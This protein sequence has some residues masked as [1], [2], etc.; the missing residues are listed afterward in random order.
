MTN[1]VEQKLDSFLNKDEAKNTEDALEAPISQEDIDAV[2]N[3]LDE[4]EM[5]EMDEDFKPTLSDESPLEKEEKYGKRENK[6]GEILTVKAYEFTKPKRFK[7]ENGVKVPIDPE[8]NE[9][10]TAQWY[11]GKLKIS[12]EEDNLIEYYPSVNYFLNNGKINQNISVY[13]EGHSVISR[14]FRKI[15]SHMSGGKFEIQKIKHNQRDSNQVNPAQLKEFE[16]FSKTKSDI[17]ILDY[18][19]GKKVKI[20]SDTGNHKGKSWFRNDIEAI[21]D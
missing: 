21:V 13:R 3:E 16:E 6:N 1:E 14:L 11:P 4:P 9:N 8:T 20:L 7:T 17:E 10:E 2:I 5:V 18:L 12:F 15:I 19:V